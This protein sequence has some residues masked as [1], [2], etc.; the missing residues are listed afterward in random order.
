MSRVRR[1]GVQTPPPRP[2]AFGAEQRP[3]AGYGGERNVS[4]LF[5]RY[6][7]LRMYYTKEEREPTLG[8]SAWPLN[9]FFLPPFA[10]N[11]DWDRNGE[12]SRTTPPR[13]GLMQ[14][15]ARSGDG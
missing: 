12:D 15:T 10:F 4:D 6:D 7:F 3:G 5:L 1:G 8:S 2:G 9:T 11:V 13:W 14:K